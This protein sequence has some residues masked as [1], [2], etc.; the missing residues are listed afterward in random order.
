MAAPSFTGSPP[1]MVRSPRVGGETQ[2][3]MRMVEDFPAPFGPR[4]PNAS[5]R[6][7]SKSIPSTAVKPP[8]RFVRPRARTSTSGTRRRIPG[9]RADSEQPSYGL[10]DIG[11]FGDL[12]RGQPGGAGKVQPGHDDGGAATVRPLP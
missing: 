1:R 12:S 8:N 7:R 11:W 2:P 9:T 6:K 4:K 3:S 5:P 10:L